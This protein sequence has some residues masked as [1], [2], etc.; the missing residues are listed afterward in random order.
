[1]T[2]T[3]WLLRAARVLACLCTLVSAGARAQTAASGEHAS[4]VLAHRAYTFVR[5]GQLGSA[6]LRTSVA[7]LEGTPTRSYGLGARFDRSLLRHL[8]AGVQLFIGGERGA[9]LDRGT[10]ENFHA[11]PLEL[12]AVVS[13]VCPCSMTGSSSARFCSRGSACSSFSRAPFRCAARARSIPTRSRRS[14]ASAPRS[15]AGS[16]SPPG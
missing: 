9:D 14:R 4:P 15:A 6:T 12:E 2:R 11:A 8:T 16:A 13:P 1:M 10:G 3:R 7:E 5:F